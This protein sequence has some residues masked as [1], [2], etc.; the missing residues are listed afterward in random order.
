MNS[1]A[2]RTVSRKLGPLNLVVN[3]AGIADEGNWR[4]TID[5]DLVG[6]YLLR[7]RSVTDLLK[8]R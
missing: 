8:Y 5:I 3:N 2:F 4:K 1:D 7:D 6:Y